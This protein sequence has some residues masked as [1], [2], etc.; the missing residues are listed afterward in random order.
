MTRLLVAMGRG[1]DL[2]QNNGNH[3]EAW[4]NKLLKVMS[5]MEG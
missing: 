4:S 1:K 5:W 2:S 3:L